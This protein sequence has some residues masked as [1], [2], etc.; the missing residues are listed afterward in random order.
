M[1]EE[2]Y[3]SVM[4]NIMNTQYKV[5]HNLCLVSGE[6][7]NESELRFVLGNPIMEMLC[8]TFDLQ[9]IYSLSFPGYQ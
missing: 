8:T 7:R 4:K 9:V 6:L 2:T 1:K 3:S 5:W